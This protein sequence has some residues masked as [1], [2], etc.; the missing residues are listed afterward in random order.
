MD[1]R[2]CIAEYDGDS[3]RYTLTVGTQGVHGVRDI[4]AEDIL[5]ID[6][7]RLHVITPDVGGGF[8]PKV[9][10]YREYPLCLVAG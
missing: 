1:T 10:V 4:L 9:F 7:A 6:P 5:K 8:G 3:G 2:G